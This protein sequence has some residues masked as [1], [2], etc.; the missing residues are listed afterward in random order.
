M[1][2]K[3][4]C[5]GC[6]GDVVYHRVYSGEQLCRRCFRES[7]V[8]K[9]RRTVS[10]YDMLRYG[11]TVAVAVSGGKDSLSLLDVLSRLAPLHGERVVAVTVDEGI[12][13]YREEAVRLAEAM[14]VKLGVAYETVSF[15]SL[16]GFTLDEAL[17]GR[18]EGGV[19]ACAVCGVLRRRAI[20]LVAEQVGADVVATAH[21]LDDFLQTFLINLM[22]GDAG[23]L[24]F[25]H[26]S[27]RPQIGLPR[28]VK[29]FTEIYEEEI[30]FYAYLSDIPFQTEPCPYMDEGIRT[31]VRRFL[32]NL[33]K[34]HLGVK[35]SAYQTTLKLLAH[36]PPTRVSRRCE[37]CG[38]PSSDTVCSTCRIIQQ[39]Q[40][41]QI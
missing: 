36:T 21:N 39:I 11:D 20:D 3:Q 2:V 37:R 33:E 29:P 22:N 30:A 17:A 19:S 24:G 18:R 8:E 25:L 9:T 40:N 26:P 4:R 41:K 23:R 35:H 6:G 34:Q 14:A 31:D 38:H 12:G 7:I 15:D 5:T 10:K 13:G 28:R 1:T 32:N 16:F 27:F